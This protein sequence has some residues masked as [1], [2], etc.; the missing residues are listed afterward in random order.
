MPLPD[1]ISKS[2]YNPAKITKIIQARIHAA[3]LKHK[4]A[5]NPICE[6]INNKVYWILPE[7]IK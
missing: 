6:W 7:Q 1:K 3:L 4:Q 2:F 5:G